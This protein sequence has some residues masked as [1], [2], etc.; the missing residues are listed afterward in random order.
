MSIGKAL[1]ITRHYL[2]DN[3]GGANATK[4]FVLAFSHVVSDMT[5]IYPE[6]DGQ[7]SSCYAPMSCRCIPC[8]DKRSK[9]RKGLDIYR[10][11]LH[12]LTDFVRKHLSECRYDAIVI[13]HSLT[14][15][16]LIDDIKDTGARII[17]IH[18]NVERDY[19]RDNKPAL[20]YRLPMV[21]FSRRAERDA[22]EKSDVN[23]TLTENDAT[24]FATWYP[25]RNLHLRSI[26]ICEYRPIPE[27]AF[28]NQTSGHTFVMTGSLCFAQSL[29]PIL[30]FVQKYYP[31]IKTTCP[32]A[33]L[34][35]AGRNPSEELLAKCSEDQSIEIVAN[36][37]NMDDVVKRANYY[38]CPI[39]AGSGI[40]LRVM[41][42]LKQ[43]LPVLA[44]EVSAIGYERVMDRGA[45][46][47]YRDEQTFTE[48]LNDLLS[49][50]YEPKM[51]YSAYRDTF[52]VDNVVR[53]LKEII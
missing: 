9:I 46:F 13:D 31:I 12:R 27:K 6:R 42:G 15:A 23:F 28:D 38:V 4:G 16:S 51:V 41:D 30:E 14:A 34:I 3:N 44:H 48:S 2:S 33:K 32:D 52:Q 10:G 37:Q 47:A 39:N 7:D 40:K 26:G 17:T 53:I 24:S 49:S 8:F 20:L 5:L 1:F 19:L 45:L 43:G 22:L 25:E 11:R 50:D 21:Y 18:H 29:R 36:P 35:I